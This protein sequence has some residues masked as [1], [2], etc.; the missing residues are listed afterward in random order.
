MKVLSDLDF[1]ISE[2]GDE[3]LIC[4]SNELVSS[5]SDKEQPQGEP[6]SSSYFT[7]EELNSMKL[8]KGKNQ[9]DF[10]GGQD[11]GNIRI[12]FSIYLFQQDDR[13]EYSTTNKI[14]LHRSIDY[15]WFLKKYFDLKY[16]VFLCFRL[17][18]TDIDGTITKSDV[19]GFL[20]GNL[21]N[22]LPSLKGKRFTS[23][24]H[25]DNVVKFLHKASSNGYVVIYL[26]ARPIDFDSQTRKYLFSSLQDRDGGYSLPESPLFSGSK[27]DLEKCTSESK[28]SYNPSIV[29][30]TTIQ[31]ILALFDL[32]EKVCQI[33]LSV[34]S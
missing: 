28:I 30:A 31:C 11:L 27:V 5:I 32:K 22:Y 12:C 24:V 18:F 17:I 14:L 1:V 13:Y 10:C 25:H 16:F 23:D 26:T 2:S 15:Y 4:R 6:V 20:G 33:Q 9:V 21:E 19:K 8:K 29:K 34:I 3:V 7:S